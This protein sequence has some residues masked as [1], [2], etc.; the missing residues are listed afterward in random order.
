MAT[1]VVVREG[2]FEPGEIPV[3]VHEC[4]GAAPPGIAG[5]VV[6]ADEAVALSKRPMRRCKL[7][8]AE[9]FD[10]CPAIRC[11]ATWC[12]PSSLQGPGGGKSCLAGTGAGKRGYRG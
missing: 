7:R 8:D 4:L 2:G 12:G 1:A 11:S 5:D 10:I 9:P 6:E 3:E